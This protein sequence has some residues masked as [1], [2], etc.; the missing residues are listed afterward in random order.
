MARKIKEVFI[1]E[2]L[3][4]SLHP[5]LEYVQLDDTLN[6]ELR[7]DEVT[8][9]YRGG[10]LL[11]IKQDTYN[12][13]G[14]TEKYHKRISFLKPS[15]GNLEEYIPKAKH[16]IDV[17][18]NTVKNLLGEKDIQQQIARENNYSQNSLDTDYFVI[19]TE[20][21]DLGRFDI[22]ALRWDSKSSIR[23]LPK[24]FLPTITIFEVKQG[25]KSISNESGMVS[26]IED[27][28][29]FRL[30]KDIEAFKMDMISVF[31]Q[32]R[33][34]RLIKGMNKYKEVTAVARDI[35]FVFLLANY[36]HDSSQLR[37]ALDIIDDCKLIF[38]N[39]MG[40]G[41][42][43]RNIVNKQQFIEKFL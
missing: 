11:T 30:T 25:Y 21:Q 6:M 33:R 5:L 17:Y 27:F 2:L 36:K 3:K 13:Y 1:E 40:Y 16:K 38:A 22:V 43:T 39:Y 14:L 19:D 9:Y 23:K 32:K 42:Y 28:E 15:I 4:G 20:Y 31:N 7:G 26:H 8:V 35:D 34:L 18:I 12:L 10:A 24:S 41:L 37:T 29:E